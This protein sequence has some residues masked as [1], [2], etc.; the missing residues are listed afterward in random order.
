MAPKQLKNSAFRS[1]IGHCL[2]SGRCNFD[3][4]IIILDMSSMGH[5]T[6]TYCGSYSASSYWISGRSNRIGIR[7]RSDQSITGHGFSL[8]YK[9]GI[10][11]SLYPSIHIPYIIDHP[12]FD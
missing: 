4:L 6:R 2:V 3:R 9:S 1:M 8:G 11:P 5:N 7:F 10:P 12:S